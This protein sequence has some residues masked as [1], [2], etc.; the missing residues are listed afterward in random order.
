MSQAL[1][2]ISIITS[3]E[4]P[5]VWRYSTSAGPVRSKFLLHLRD[6]QKI[7]G[8]KCPSCGRVY[9]PAKSTC[10]KCFENMTEWV[11]VSDEGTLETFTVVHEPAPAYP[12]KTPFA[13]GV[14]KL[15]GADTGLAHRLGEVDFEKISIGMRFKAVF[16]DEVKGHIRDIKYFK[17]AKGV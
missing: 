16:E 2:G 9:V 3:D 11:D 10:I 7:K 5:R 4:R 6:E 14:I 15:D 8:T 12:Y 17:P 13:F 1:E